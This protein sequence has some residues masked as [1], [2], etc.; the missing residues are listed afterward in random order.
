MLP[1]PRA[2]TLQPAYRALIDAL[3]S[4]YVTPGTLAQRWSW[5]E[6]HL[7]NLRKAGKGPAFV[8][9]GR[10]VRYSVAEVIAWEVAGASH[11]VTRERVA[12]ACAALTGLSAE[13]RL[14]VS[15]QLDSLL[16]QRKA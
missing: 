4:C 6:Q 2:L 12:L 5:S 13:Q 11:H 14:A 16:F 7:A 10:S 9:M 3:E 15:E 1:A 8:K